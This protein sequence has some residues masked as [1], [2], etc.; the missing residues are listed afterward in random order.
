[1]RN[2][3]YLLVR[4]SAIVLFVIL[5]V[6]SFYLIINYNK[7]QK[8]IWA[9]SSNLLTGTVNEKVSG[10]QNYFDLQNTNDS[11][12]RENAK[13]LETIINYRVSSRD[14]SFQKYERSDSI[15]SYEMIPARVCGQ[16]LNLRNNYMTL[17]KGEDDGI[18]V[19]MGVVTAKGVV[20]IV[21]ATSGKFATV[22]MILNSQSRVG[23]QIK[24]KNYHGVLIWDSDDI[25]KMTLIDLPKH[26]EISKG[27]TIL[28]SGYSVAFPPDLYLGTIEDFEIEGGSNNYR[29]TVN[30]DYP[31]ANLEYVYVVKFI[32]AEEKAELIA[33]EDE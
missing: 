21:K 30:R 20:G 29:I 16:T 26:A 31:I 17:C 1:M 8:E 22:L 32:D 19:G 12:L 10:V 15:R 7:S 9:H 3:I 4:Y 25:E 28:T 18:Q 27:D 14:N 13:L 5:E 11:L 33:N 2:L 24:D 6:V 23:A